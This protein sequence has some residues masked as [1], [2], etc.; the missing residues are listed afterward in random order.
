MSMRQPIYTPEGPIEVSLVGGTEK[1][2]P[3]CSGP[4][5]GSLRMRWS[6]RKLILLNSGADDMTVRVW[7]ADIVGGSGVS[8][9]VTLWP[10]DRE[11]VE[12]P[13]HLLG[14]RRVEASFGAGLTESEEDAAHVLGAS[15]GAPA[16]GYWH[17]RVDRSREPWVFSFET[18]PYRR[19]VRAWTG[20]YP[21]P[22]AEFWMGVGD[23][24]LVSPGQWMQG[25]VDGRWSRLTDVDRR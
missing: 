4:A 11:E 17:Y 2:V 10:G 23:T 6:G 21:S 1:G 19:Y 15:D 25:L 9:R 24:H 3:P 18:P 14:V 8:Q 5:C 13:R 7:F 22:Y 16:E 20:P 12:I